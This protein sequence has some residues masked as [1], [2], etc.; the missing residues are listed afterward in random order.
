MQNVMFQSELMYS[1]VISSGLVCVI[2]PWKKSA[3]STKQRYT[4]V[5]SLC[6]KENAFIILA[7]WQSFDALTEN[8]K[9]N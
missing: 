8:V 9:D 5:I 4:K 1:E 3:P 2:S 7:A 6:Q